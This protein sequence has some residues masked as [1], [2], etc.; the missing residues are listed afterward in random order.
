MYLANNW[1]IGGK[2]RHIDV[3]SV[4]LQ[5]PKEAGILVIKWIARTT[6]E[7]GIFNKNLDEPTFQRFTKIFMGRTD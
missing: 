7:A 5:E 3:Q 6:N 1:S 4:F 2:T